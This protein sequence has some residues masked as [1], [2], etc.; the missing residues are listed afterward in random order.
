MKAKRVGGGREKWG[1]KKIKEYKG[2]M[3]LMDSTDQISLYSS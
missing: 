3:A 2:C 1:A